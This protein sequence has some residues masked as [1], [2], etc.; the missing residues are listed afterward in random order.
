MRL[1]QTPT[2]PN[3]KQKMQTLKEKFEKAG[4]AHVFKFFDELDVAQQNAL[5]EQ[6]K[7]IDL[8]E[9][10]R[11]NETLV[12]AENTDA[13][14]DFAKLTPAPYSPLPADKAND[15]EWAN[16]KKIGEGA[17]KAGKLAA[18]VVA[19]GQGT[20]LGFNAPKGLY[21]VTPVK[22]KS[23]FQV[24]AE[25]ILSASKKYGVSIP[26]IVM[27][28]HI[29]NKATVE[30]FEENNF[31][32]LDKNDIIF[33]KQG[34]MPAVDLNGKIILE[35]KGK[36]AMTPDGHGGCLRGMVRSGAI[37][38]LKKRGIECVSYF[39]VDNPLVDIID[40]YFVGFHILGKS[41]MSSKMIAKAYP[42]EKVGHFC[43]LDDKLTVVE[44]S[45]LPNEYQEQTD[46][47]GKLKF[48]AGSVA[49][50]ILDVDFIETLGSSQKEEDRLPFHR[51]NKKIPFVGDDGQPVKP[52]KPNGVKFEMFVFDALPMAKNPVIIEGFRGDEFSPVKNAEG[53]DSPLTCKNHQKAQWC[54]WFAKVGVEIEADADGIPAI[55]FEV[56]PLF[57]SNEA[58][59]VAKWNAL[60]DKPSVE[61]GLYLQ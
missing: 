53:V 56:S 51:A 38:E 28:S 60:A 9:L 8:D 27:T 19:G 43:M 34:L 6:L 10:A 59:F 49:I 54:R 58:D 18:F 13:G 44:Y 1:Y 37:A 7:M 41:Q 31:F 29:N 25:K 26:W 39:Q 23:L 5:V 11:L 33:F 45:D 52:E 42:L 35:D 20:R 61:N 15:P 3:K 30:F 47:N 36:I 46:E 2:F 48:I 17:I 21:K 57:A 14:I 40:P 50:H 4:Q 12:F 24:F 32:G 16:A 55:D 22:Q